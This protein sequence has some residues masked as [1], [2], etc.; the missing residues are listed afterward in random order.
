MA[1]TLNDLRTEVRANV[2]ATQLP[3]N[4]IDLWA[5]LAQ[6]QILRVLDPEFLK[7]TTTI[8]TASSTRLYFVQSSINRILSVVDQTNLKTLTQE[9]ETR[10][11][12]A[13][14]G[15]DDGGSPSFYSL[16]GMSYVN[17][18]PSSA[19]AIRIVSSDNTDTTQQVQLV[20]ISS[21]SEID[22]TL[23]LNGTVNVNG[24]VSFTTLL[25]V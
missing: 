15:L 14:P 5:N 17:Q 9:S 24:T 4:R 6:D 3:T 25:R 20:G 18:Q 11:E 2:K 7:E 22:E 10:V 13:D 19:S 1:L 23:T 21:G 12:R 8:T 16:F